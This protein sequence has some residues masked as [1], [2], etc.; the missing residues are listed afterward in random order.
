MTFVM[1]NTLLEEVTKNK[2]SSCLL[3]LTFSI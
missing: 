3:W 1:N 2:G